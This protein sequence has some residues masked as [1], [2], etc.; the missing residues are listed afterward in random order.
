MQ[1]IRRGASAS[2][3]ARNPALRQS[4]TPQVEPA[5]GARRKVPRSQSRR[6]AAG[7]QR[8]GWATGPPCSTRSRGSARGARRM[9]QRFRS[10]S[11]ERPTPMHSLGTSSYGG[12]SGGASE[13]ETVAPAPMPREKACRGS[14]HGWTQPC[15]DAQGW[16]DAEREEGRFERSNPKSISI[17]IRSRPQPSVTV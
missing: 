2:A 7:M 8:P 1:V 9:H 3:R 17:E 13:E 5:G 12:K 10:G 6:R 16:V 15:V 11:R 14:N 4:R